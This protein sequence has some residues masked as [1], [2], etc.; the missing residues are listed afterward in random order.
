MCFLNLFTFL[1]NWH[2]YLIPTFL[3]THVRTVCTAGSYASNFLAKNF[4][5]QNS[6][7]TQTLIL[8]EMTLGQ[9]DRKPDVRH[10]QDKP[11]KL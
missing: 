7:V 10:V 2:F 6:S 9:L 1:D 4:G 11:L 5:H 8:G 3:G